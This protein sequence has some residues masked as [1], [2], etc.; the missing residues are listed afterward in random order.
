VDSKLVREKKPQ[1]MDQEEAII[2]EIQI[3]NLQVQLGGA[4]IVTAATGSLNGSVLFLDD[5]QI[6]GQWP[7]SGSVYRVS[8]SGM[9]AGDFTYSSYQRSATGYRLKFNQFAE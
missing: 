5:A 7:S 1:S 4:V 6:P 3:N 9:T 2:P 8:G